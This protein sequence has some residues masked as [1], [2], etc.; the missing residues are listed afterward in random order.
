[1]KDEITD[2]QEIAIMESVNILSNDAKI[3]LATKILKGISVQV[4]RVKNG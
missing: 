4:A 1:L 2:P 3:R